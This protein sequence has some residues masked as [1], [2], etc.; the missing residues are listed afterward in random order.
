MSKEHELRGEVVAFVKA[1]RCSGLK[2]D[3]SETEKL[4]HGWTVLLMLQK[5]AGTQ[6]PSSLDS[7]LVILG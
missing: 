5:Q 3:R 4:K 2:I 1:C 6:M 7:F